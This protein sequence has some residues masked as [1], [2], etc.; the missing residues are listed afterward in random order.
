[1]KWVEFKDNLM[2]STGLER[3]ALHVYAALL[4]SIAAAFLLRRS[5]ASVLPWL[6]VLALEIAN[7]ALDIYWDGL[8]EQ[9]EIDGAKHDLWNTM[10]APTFLLLTAR[11]MPGVYCA[12]VR[13]K[14][15]P[16]DQEQDGD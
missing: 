5:I 16:V 9:W 3:D 13:P 12:K 15:E 14:T 10:I 4:A 8:V 1:M 7:E 11:L 6:A 2:L